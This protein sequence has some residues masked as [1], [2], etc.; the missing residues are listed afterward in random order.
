MV[1]YYRQIIPNVAFVFLLQTSGT[2][3]YAKN[4]DIKGR[5]A[6]VVVESEVKNEFSEPKTVSLEVEIKDLDG[7]IV[8]TFTGNTQTIQPAET[9]ILSANTPLSD[10]HF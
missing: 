1:A 4:F 8:K 2:Y 5:K 3:V 7:K 9:K 6:T 10:L